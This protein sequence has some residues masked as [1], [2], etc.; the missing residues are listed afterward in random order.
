MLYRGKYFILDIEWHIVGYSSYIVSHI[1]HKGI[2]LNHLCTLTAFGIVFAESIFI[3]NMKLSLEFP[4]FL[5]A[6]GTL[7]LLLSVL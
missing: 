3:A 1:T 4:S 2:L 7:I 5:A 6:V